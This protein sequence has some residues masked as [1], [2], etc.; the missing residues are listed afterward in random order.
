M[1]RF[2]FLGLILAVA[3]VAVFLL[4]V[5]TAEAQGACAGSLAQRLNVGDD[6]RVARSFSSLRSAPGGPAFRIMYYG[7]T[8]TVIGGPQCVGGLLYLQ[9]DYGGGV[10]GWATESQVTSVWGNNLYWLEPVS[11]TPPPSPP[12]PPASGE[13]AGSLPAQLNVGDTGRVARAFSSLRSSPAGPVVRIMPT[14]STFTV[15]AG[16]TCAGYGPLTWY[17]VDYGGGVV[18]WASESQR[19]SVWGN[20]LYWLEP[21]GGS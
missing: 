20:N 14:G 16:P 5:G 10:T 15:L 11:A 21:V 2:K 3:L 18:G 19:T 6:G 4:P 9:V 1:Q 17:Q 12:V 7:A 8:F 13:C